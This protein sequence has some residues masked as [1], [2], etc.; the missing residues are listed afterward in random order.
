M[1]KWCGM[2]WIGF[3]SWK[4]QQMDQ[5]DFLWPARKSLYCWLEV[6]VDHAWAR[7]KQTASAET[8][9]PI[10]SV[11]SCIQPC[12][13]TMCWCRQML[14]TWLHPCWTK[15]AFFRASLSLHSPIQPIHSLLNPSR[16]CSP[17]TPRRPHN[18]NSSNK[19]VSSPSKWC[20]TENSSR[21]VPNTAVSESQPH[22]R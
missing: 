1:S 20:S 7:T 6:C 4:L 12:H 9:Q 11:P 14:T 2:A 17:V 15:F 22:K 21:R 13:V 8:Q 18:L 19:L 5:S 3:C 16:Y 10:A